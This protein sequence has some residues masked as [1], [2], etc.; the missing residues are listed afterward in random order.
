MKVTKYNHSCLLIEDVEK[1]TLID[2]GNFS[3]NV[4]IPEQL[5]KL[6][7]L[8]ITHEHIDHF[9]MPLVKKIAAI[10]PNIT[11]ITTTPIVE[12]LM[13]EHVTATT[14]GDE[15]ITVATVP[16]ERNWGI[17]PPK[18]ILV[19]IGGLITHPGDSHTFD[20]TTDVLALPITAP[21]GSTTAA[22]DLAQKLK[23]KTIIPIHDYM[24]KDESRRMLYTWL[25]AFLQPQGIELKKI[26]TGQPFEV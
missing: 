18:N 11:I 13:N 21:W 20:T 4:L 2:P 25:E 6:D 16:H 5:P 17:N 9:S 26:E 1:N 10:F 7:Y 3:E 23:P 24:L 15:Y 14:E 22:V 12:Q 8:L 19:T